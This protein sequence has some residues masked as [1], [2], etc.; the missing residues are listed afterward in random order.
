MIF[1]LTKPP[2]NPDD[3]LDGLS[4]AARLLNVFAADGLSP[5]D[6]R[7]VAVFHGAAGYAAMSNNLYSSKFKTDNPNLKIIQ[8]LKASGVQL[9]LCGQT[10]H[11]FNFRETELLPEVKLATSAAIV[12]VTYQNEGCAL[13]PF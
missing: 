6:L 13:M 3:V 5:K 2:A 10:F 12:L 1:D 4:H 9:F 11:D 7:V 8:E